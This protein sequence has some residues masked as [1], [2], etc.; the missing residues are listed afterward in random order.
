MGVEHMGDI[1]IK[2]DWIAPGNSAAKLLG[3]IAHLGTI[4]DA[5]QPLGVHSEQSVKL[6]ES[7]LA[8]ALR[9]D[10]DFGVGMALP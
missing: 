9:R 2:P 3:C 10:P 8:E 1:G 5:G 7:G 4:H 6:V